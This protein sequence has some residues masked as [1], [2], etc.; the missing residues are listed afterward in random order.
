MDYLNKYDEMKR[1]LDDKFEMPDKT[2]ALLIK[3]LG[4]GDG[5][6]SKRARGKELVAL[7]DEEIR[8]IE[9]RYQ[10]IFLEG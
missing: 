2:V 8:D 10:E 5:Q 1:Y 6:L 7:T 9:N 3:F 4:Q